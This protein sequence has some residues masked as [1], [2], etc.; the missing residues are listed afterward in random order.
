MIG[1]LHGKVVAP[2]TSMVADYGRR[3]ELRVYFSQF[4]DDASAARAL[5]AML[6]GMSTGRTPFARPQK[7]PGGT[8][9]W[10]TFG[11]GGH[12]LLWVSK[13]CVYWLQ[14]APGTVEDAA[15]ELPAPTMGVWT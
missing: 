9:R 2:R 5:D 7:E 12:H 6:V 8:G 14:G 11:P 10:V 1:K 4:S 3:G 13:G 15:A